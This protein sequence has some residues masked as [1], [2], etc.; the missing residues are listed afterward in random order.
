MM[1][2]FHIVF[3]RLSTPTITTARQSNSDRKPPF[4]II[5]PLYLL[6]LPTNLTPFSYQYCNGFLQS[7][8]S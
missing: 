8:Y 7:E 4:D 3:A 5:C 6:Y 1:Y 2:S